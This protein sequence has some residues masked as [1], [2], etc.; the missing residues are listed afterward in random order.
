MSYDIYFGPVLDEP[1]RNYTSNV[2][3]MWTAAI[4]ENLGD[5]ID[6]LP[7]AGDLVP[8]VRRGVAAMRADPERYRAMNPENGW[9]DYEGALAYLEWVFR[10]AETWPDLTVE[11]SR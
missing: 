9:G 6:R 2:S 5:L 4:G 11:A 3:P 10:T 7:R 8:H 1:E